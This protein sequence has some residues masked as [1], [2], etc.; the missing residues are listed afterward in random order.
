MAH[1]LTQQNS[2]KR[3]AGPSASTSWQHPTAPGDKC[4][5]ASAGIGNGFSSRLRQPFDRT[6]IV[7]YPRSDSKGT[8]TRPSSLPAKG[9][10]KAIFTTQDISSGAP[11]W[12]TYAP[13]ISTR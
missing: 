13:S 12:T 8:H 4:N 9:L 2:L 11:C 10:Y 7:P 3:T 6:Q 5:I 1:L